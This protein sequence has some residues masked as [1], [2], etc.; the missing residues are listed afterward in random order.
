[1]SSLFFFPFFFVAF[2]F[3]A[4][5]RVETDVTADADRKCASRT[6]R[7]SVFAAAEADNIDAMRLQGVRGCAFTMANR[8]NPTHTLYGEHILANHKTS[9]ETS[10]YRKTVEYGIV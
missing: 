6:A 7:L 1:V 10:D 3:D 4:K 8:A 2:F 5:L 9:S